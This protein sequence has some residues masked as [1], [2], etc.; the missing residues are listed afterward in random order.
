MFIV[1]TE[2]DLQAWGRGHVLI[3]HWAVEHLPEWQQALTGRDHFKDL[4][5]KYTHIQD[6]HSGGKSPDLDKY[7][8][9]PAP[10]LSLH[11]VQPIENGA[12]AMQW[13]LYQICEHIRKGEKDEAMKFLGVL[14][15]W[16]EDPG[17]PSMHSSPV[18]ETVLRQLI[19]PPKD[20]ENLNYLFGYG[21][22]CKLEKFT[23]PDM[24]YTPRLLGASI[25]E[26]G[27]RIYQAQRILRFHNSQYIIP[28]VQDAMYGDGTK[29]DEVR[30]KAALYNAK[31]VADVIYTTLCLATG[32]L[33]PREAEAPARQPLTEWLS[34]FTGAMIGHP[35]YVTPFLIGQ[36]MDAKRALHPLAFSGGEK[37]AFGLGMGAPFALDYTI[38]PGGVY[39]HFTC[40]VGLHPTAG[41]KGEVAFQVLVNGK[42]AAKTEPIPSG[43]PPQLLRVDLPD[44]P[45]VKLTLTTV[46]APGAPSLDNLTVWGEPTLHRAESAPA[47]IPPAP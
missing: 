36:A 4:C 25:T 9:P 22:V 3:R 19:P 23:I 1:I 17:S 28:V 44:T 24:A 35:Y 42:I 32:R 39:S 45:V 41:E 2:S 38:A 30:S 29:A 5:T 12:P 15:H 31:H 27:G 26:A 8:Y 13:Y 33:D 43:A 14:C 21:G 7:C 37:V 18:T 34:D 10:R 20:K 40:R 11:D 16:N 46:P 6:Q 47:Y